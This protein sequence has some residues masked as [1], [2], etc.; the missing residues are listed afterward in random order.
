MLARECVWWTKFEVQKQKNKN[1]SKM[2]S[3]VICTAQCAASDLSFF[4]L[5]PFILSVEPERILK[6]PIWAATEYNTL[7]QSEDSHKSWCLAKLT[8][9]FL[10]MRPCTIQLSTVQQILPLLMTWTL[11]DQSPFSLTGTPD[12]EWSLPKALI[13]SP[14]LTHSA[15]LMTREPLA[16][17][18][19]KIIALLVARGC[20]L[21]CSRSSQV[22]K[23][24]WLSDSQ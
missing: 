14:S 22:L 17:G 4:R 9:L 2:F 23:A 12:E 11:R 13:K 5:V 7:G 19:V 3:S 16:A 15:L 21:R 6:D 24:Q 10:L 18:V 20:H 8:S 1:V